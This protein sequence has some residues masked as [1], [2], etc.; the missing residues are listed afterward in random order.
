[1]SVRVISDKVAKFMMVMA[2]TWAF[3]LTFVIMADIISRGAFNEP[4]NGVREIVA[5]SIVI[6]VFLQ[7]GYAIR[8]RSMLSADFLIDHFPSVLRRVALGFGYLLGVVFFVLIIWGG[9]QLAIDSWVGGEFEGEGALRVP[10][11]P[12]RFMILLGSALA[13]ANY[14]VMAYLDVF[15]PGDASSGGDGTDADFRPAPRH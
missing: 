8:S 2:A 4:L 12:T 1:M 13:I 3:I 9:W 14:L 7:A 10:A 5:N 6:I 15:R 11:W